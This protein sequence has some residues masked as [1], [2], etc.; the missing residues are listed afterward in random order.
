M[1]MSIGLRSDFLRIPIYRVICEFK[2][3]DFLLM[4]S[5]HLDQFQFLPLALMRT[6]G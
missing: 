6:E 5:T 2:K 4:R 1:I 3:Y